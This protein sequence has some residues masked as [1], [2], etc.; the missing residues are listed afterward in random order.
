LHIQLHFEL[1]NISIL[2]LLLS[3]NLTLHVTLLVLLYLDQSLLG[4]YLDPQC[5]S[6]IVKL[7]LLLPE[8]VESINEGLYTG[9]SVLS[10]LVNDLLSCPDPVSEDASLRGDPLYILY[11]V[12]HVFLILYFFLDMFGFVVLMSVVVH[13]NISNHL[14]KLMS[15]FHTD[16]ALLLVFCDDVLELFIACLQ[17]LVVVFKLLILNCELVYE[18]LDGINQFN[19][20]TILAKLF[21]LDVLEYL[22][23][24]RVLESRIESVCGE[25]AS[26]KALQALI[27]LLHF[28]RSV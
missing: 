26:A 1:A 12:C 7:L 25:T 21:T 27:L 22:H 24:V 4:L 11:H 16:L 3:L 2:I 19:G 17:L 8:F 5:L 20:F 23:T 14:T 10:E 15:F 9:L 18:F 28:T 6:L 13:L